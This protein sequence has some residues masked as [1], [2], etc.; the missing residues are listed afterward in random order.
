MSNSAPHRIQIRFSPF[1]SALGS[2]SMML[3]VIIRIATSIFHLIL[4]RTHTKN[5]V[6]LADSGQMFK[7]NECNAMSV[8]NLSNQ[9]NVFLLIFKFSTNQQNSTFV[10]CFWFVIPYNEKLTVGFVFIFV[11]QR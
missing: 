1:K 9:L 8:Q 7:K 6:F 4:S 3:I 5:C 2:Q 10:Y 11:I